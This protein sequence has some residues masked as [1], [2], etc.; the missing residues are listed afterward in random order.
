MAMRV[1][2]LA[3][4]DR[5][6]ASTRHRFLQFAPHLADEGIH[7]ELSPLF[8]DDYLAARFEHGRA[9]LRTVREAVLRRLAALLSA[10]RYDLVFLAYEAFPYLPAVAE[11]LFGLLGVPYVVDY[12]DAIFHAYDQHPSRLIRGLLGGKIGRVMKNARGVIAGS[13]YLAAYA[14]QHNPRVFVIPTVIDLE[15]YTVRPPATSTRTFTVGWIGS[16]ST[17]AYLRELAGPLQRLGAQLPLR[18]VAV[19]AKPLAIPG[20]EVD[21]RPWSE[22][23]EVSDL[24]ECDAGIMPLPDT[25]WTRGKCAFKLIQYMACGLPAVGSAVGANRDVIAE[26]ETG[27][28]VSGDEG[29]IAALTRLAQDPELRARLGAAGRRR[30]EER[31]SLASQAPRLAEALRSLRP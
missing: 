24:L 26:G 29:W 25:P 21:V 15:R 10:R 1:L 23:T 2:V 14:R 19:G 16:P 6:A 9:P 28:L 11:E 7:L 22:A 20:V 8:G 4:Y 12:D 17:S 5:M 31:F 18:L 3:K 30:A 27:F 13:E